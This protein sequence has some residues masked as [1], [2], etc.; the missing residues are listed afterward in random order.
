MYA[1][2]ERF[3]PR[4]ELVETPSKV[5][6]CSRVLHIVPIVIDIAVRSLIS[7][8]LTTRRPGT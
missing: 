8:S 3:N 4:N 7:D 6:G 2:N 5:S 1:P